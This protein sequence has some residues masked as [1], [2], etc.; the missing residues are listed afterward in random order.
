MIRQ[1]RDKES[2]PAQK[3]MNIR[4]SRKHFIE[5][6][7]L[8]FSNKDLILYLTFSKEYLPG[9]KKEA[10]NCLKKY[11]ARL[12]YQ[13]EKLSLGSLK[14][15]YIISI[16]K[17]P[18]CQEEYHIDLLINNIKIDVT[19]PLWRYGTVYNNKF[20]YASEL[21]AT[22]QTSNGTG[23]G[24]REKSWQGSIGLIKPA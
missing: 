20:Q 9:S 21:R 3:K 6:A 7:N 10:Y 4:N 16:A 23:W 14:Y 19:E 22:K 8:N 17:E 11:L 1:K 13:I 5:A 2:T 18:G 12:R 15:L 24:E